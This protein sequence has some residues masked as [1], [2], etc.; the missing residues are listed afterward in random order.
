[1]TWEL[2]TL[3]SLLKPEATSWFTSDRKKLCNAANFVAVLFEAMN[4]FNHSVAQVG[5]QLPLAA[6][7]MTTPG[8]SPTRTS[9]VLGL[10]M[11]DFGVTQAL[12]QDEPLVPL[13]SCFGGA[14][15]V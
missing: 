9:Q 15:L 3:F 10:Y 8:M 2:G 11:D 7:D 13:E 1:M 4:L 14:Q 6:A 5:R 12:G